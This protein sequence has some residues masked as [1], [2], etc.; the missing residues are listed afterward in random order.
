V[1]NFG[2]MFLVTQYSVKTIAI[3]HFFM[4]AKWKVLFSE[5]STNM[6]LMYC[7]NNYSRKD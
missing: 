2:N 3:E 1:K 6:I 7:Y 4:N 5:I